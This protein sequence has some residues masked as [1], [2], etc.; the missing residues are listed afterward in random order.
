M[1]ILI[2][3]ISGLNFCANCRFRS[4]KHHSKFY[5]FSL[6]PLVFYQTPIN[7]ITSLFPRSQSSSKVF[8]LFIL[9][10]YNRY[11]RFL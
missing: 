4:L 3:Q 7:L 10:L 1:L 2:H 9:L 8:S 11:F 5:I 6:C